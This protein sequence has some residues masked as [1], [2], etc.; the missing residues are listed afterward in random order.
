MLTKEHETMLIAKKGI[1]T[2]I[3]LWR[4][5][6]VGPISKTETPKCNV[7]KNM[8]SAG[9]LTRAEWNARVTV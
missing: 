7:A 2:P 3:P 6:T 4:P 9:D 8:L 1:N 5:S